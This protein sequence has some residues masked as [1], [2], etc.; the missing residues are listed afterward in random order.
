MIPENLN[1]CQVGTVGEQFVRY[2]L[3]RWG[4]EAIMMEQGNDYDIIVIDKKPVR[5]QVKSAK[6]IDPNRTN[7]YKFTTSKGSAKK[8]TYEKDNVDCFAF[9]ALDIE[10][11]IFFEPITAKCKRIRAENFTSSAGYDSWCGILA[12]IQKM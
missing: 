9:V 11:I 12:D 4:F 5:I 8:Q 10:R 1:A 6:T 7:S 2:K 3:M